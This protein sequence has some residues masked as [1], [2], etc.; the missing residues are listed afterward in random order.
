MSPWHA[1]H[2]LDTHKGLYD[3][4][5]FIYTDDGKTV[6]RQSFYTVSHEFNWEGGNKGCTLRKMCILVLK[7]DFRRS[8]LVTVTCHSR[9]I[10]MLLAT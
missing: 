5:N 7:K 6:F 1:C 9:S 2:L 8:D 10:S 3:E 4:R